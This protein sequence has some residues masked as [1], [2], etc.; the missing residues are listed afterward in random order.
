[1]V[2]RYAVANFVASLASMVFW[3]ALKNVL[4]TASRMPLRIYY[5]DSGGGVFASFCRLAWINFI[6]RLTFTSFSKSP[7]AR[8]GSG[9][10]HMPTTLRVI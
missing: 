5:A 1:M 8:L 10:L 3:S 9:P 2:C 6:P 4:S 7:D